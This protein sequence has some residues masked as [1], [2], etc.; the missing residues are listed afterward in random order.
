MY[1]YFYISQLFF[2]TLIYFYV[3]VYFVNEN[4]RSPNADR[5]ADQTQYDAEQKPV[6]LPKQKQKRQNYK[7]KVWK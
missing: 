2:I 7:N 6:I 3:S 1:N 4:A 5:A